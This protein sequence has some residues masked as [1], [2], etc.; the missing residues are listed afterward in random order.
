MDYYNFFSLYVKISK[1]NY[2]EI[3]RETVLNRANNY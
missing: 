2:Y 1:T 3:N